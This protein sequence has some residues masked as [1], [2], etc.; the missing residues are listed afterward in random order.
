MYTVADVRQV[1]GTALAEVDERATIATRLG[2]LLQELVAISA[3]AARRRTAR[4]PLGPLLKSDIAN[5]LGRKHG[6]RRYLEICT[7]TTGWQ[8]SAVD[9]RQYTSCR[10]LIYR[11]ARPR[12]SLPTTD[13]LVRSEAIGGAALVAL[14]VG[15]PYDLVFID[16]WHSYQCSLRDIRLGWSLLA[17]DGIL[18][19]HD[20]SPPNIAVAGPNFRPGAWWGLTYAAFVDFSLAEPGIDFYTVDADCGCAV[21]RRRKH[22][23]DAAEGEPP[24]AELAAGWR[25]TAEDHR[26]RFTYFDERR[27]QLIRPMAADRFLDAEG[28]R[29]LLADGGAGFGR[30]VKAAGA[31]PR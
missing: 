9:R 27:A 2:R 17:E 23:A 15:A 12:W 5:L 10:R 31:S 3:S 26:Q 6:F 20:C 8:Y 28:L 18:V 16:P 21:I 25:S 29:S 11:C 4:F 13:I 1:P 7:P 19:V 24:S 22:G 14:A 30:P